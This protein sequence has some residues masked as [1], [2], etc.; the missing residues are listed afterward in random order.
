[1]M[2]RVCWKE[3]QGRSSIA[4]GSGGDQDDEESGLLERVRLFISQIIWGPREDIGM[5]SECQKTTDLFFG[6]M[7]MFLIIGRNGQVFQD[8]RYMKCCL[9]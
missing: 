1:M 6:E 3:F 2:S 5:I 9:D 4:D 8:V 7:K